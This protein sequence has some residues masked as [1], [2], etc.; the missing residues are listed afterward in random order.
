VPLSKSTAAFEGPRRGDGQKAEESGG[1]ITL[2]IAHSQTPVRSALAQ[3]E[4][5]RETPSIPVLLALLAARR[6][7]LRI[8]EALAVVV[9]A[10]RVPP[11]PDAGAAPVAGHDPGYE[12]R[13]Q[14]REDD[15]TD[16]KRYGVSM[17][18][19]NTV[20]GV[21]TPGRPRRWRSASGGSS[22]G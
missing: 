5:Q 13:D 14:C 3:D 9:A 12:H 7:Q 18:A 20:V 4:L 10:R 2:G 21:R 22:A 17:I 6:L 1:P 16:Q 19:P 11:T 8:E 15:A